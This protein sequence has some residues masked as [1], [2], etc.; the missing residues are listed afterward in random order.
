MGISVIVE[1]NVDVKNAYIL[2]PY[3]QIDTWPSLAPTV[4]GR[5]FK[6]ETRTRTRIEPEYTELL[7]YSGFR[8]RVRFLYVLYFG[9]WVRVRFLTFKTRIDRITQ[10]IKK[11]LI[12][13]DII[14]WFMNFLAKNCDIILKIVYISQYAIF[15]S[16]LL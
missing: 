12:Y 8:V 16:H 11:L 10:N 4:R 7:V 1:Q 13:D 14:I 6:T 2:G 3:L 5:H 15:Y 9:V